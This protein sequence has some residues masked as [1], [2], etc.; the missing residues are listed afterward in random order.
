[1]SWAITAVGSL[2]KATGANLRTLSVSPTTI[3]DLLVLWIVA[4]G[5]FHTS[6]AVSGGGVSTWNKGA[7][8]LDSTN[9]GDAE[10]WW[11]VV[12]TTGAAT[13]TITNSTGAS[14][15]FNLASL[16]FTAGAGYGW[17][18]DGSGGTYNAGGSAA[19]GNYPS[20][21][22]LGSG[23]LFAG[24]GAMLGGTIGGNTPGYTYYS[25]AAGGFE[26]L[27]QIVYNLSAPNPADPAWSQVSN[28]YDLADI[29]LIAT[30]TVQQ[31]ISITRRHIPRRL[32]YISPELVRDNIIAI[33][34]PYFNSGT[35]L[36]T[37]AVSPQEVG[38]L[39]VVAAWEDTGNAIPGL[40][41]I[42]GGGVSNWQKIIATP[43][44]YGAFAQASELWY[45][46][47]TTAGPATITF[48]WGQSPT[49]QLI[50]Y[51]CGEFQ[52]VY[53]P[54]TLWTTDVYGSIYNNSATPTIPFP[55]LTPRGQSELYWGYAITRSGAGTAGTPA[56]DTWVPVSLGNLVVWNVN[57]PPGPH[58]PVGTLSVSDFSVALG[59]IFIGSDSRLY[60]PPVPAGFARAPRHARQA[61]GRSALILPSHLVTPGP[62]LH[63]A[64]QIALPPRSRRIETIPTTVVVT[65]PKAIPAV[66]RPKVVFGWLTRRRPVETVTPQRNPPLTP[67]VVSRARFLRGARIGGRSR[68][69]PSWPQGAGLSALLRPGA[70]TRAA[71]TGRRGA[72]P[73]APVEQS[74]PSRLQARRA[75]AVAAVRP[76]KPTQY[77][78]AQVI[79]AAPFLAPRVTRGRLIMAAVRGP[80]RL[81]QVVPPP[82]QVPS[83]GYPEIIFVDG[84]PAL[85]V[86]GL[87][88]TMLG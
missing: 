75:V 52:S 15:T 72:Q 31:T 58:S 17:S 65:T 34:A 53:G 33:N 29:L 23:E 61:R 48:N 30:G 27:S 55:T 7:Q 60:Q 10:V 18:Q 50:Q 87:W 19:S 63:K 3:G 64:P 44:T 67:Q 80:G 26:T 47:V 9:G 20:L 68:V 84:H 74:Q 38:D 8:A 66:S 88:Y 14:I 32:R 71:S 22:P 83:S 78:P 5:A 2:V 39:L 4:P 69:E 57:T 46:T 51:V 21:T 82:P 45:G 70:R 36:T 40:T 85:H 77:V 76:R 43:G 1:M 12:T 25:G 16:Q 35:G 86:A 62:L 81:I 37:L 59:A 6:T 13:I 49:G 54:F 79:V 41:S 56:A 24:C 73:Q 11:G 28:H 42:S